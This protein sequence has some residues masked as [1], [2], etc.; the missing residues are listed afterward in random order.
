MNSPFHANRK[1]SRYIRS[2]RLSRAFPFWIVLSILLLLVWSGC[3]KQEEP[4]PKVV[5]RPVK[6]MT[7]AGSQKQFK[8]AFP[9]KVEASKQVDLAFKVSGPLIELPVMEGQEVKKGDLIA[10][11]DPR[12]FETE[13]SKI[14][15]AIGEARAKLDAMQAGARPEDIKVL[16]AEIEAAEARALNAEQ[17]YKRY[18]NLYVNKQ[19]SKAD[20]DRYKSDRDVANA[21]LN[22]AQQNL[23]TGKKGSRKEDVAAMKANIRGLKAQRKGVRDALADTRLTAPFFGYIADKFVDNFQ[24]VRAKQPI[25]RLQDVASVEID[26]NVPESMVA[27]YKDHESATIT[28]EFATA[29]GKQYP[30]QVKE[31]STSA[32]P[33]TQTYK[34]TLIMPQP[35][36]ITIWPGMTANVQLTR[37]AGGVDVTAIIIPA[38][39]IFADETG[40]SHVWVY[41]AETRTVQKRMITTGDLTGTDSIRITDGL[42]T[43][44]TIAVAGVSR[45][46]EGLLVRPMDP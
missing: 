8:R 3:G 43:G 6:M 15:S 41:N 11:I 46:R 34:L 26:I 24:E 22:T 14:E 44:E 16:E 21:Q 12:D 42:K 19:V 17:Q 20:F 4:P 7:V 1:R 29:P 25:V 32:D 45:L 27:T 28:A 13:L 40:Q 9:G 33:R 37:A 23:D 2:K 36:D 18:K 10:R 39:A 30:L 38:V 5:E 35:D 31:F